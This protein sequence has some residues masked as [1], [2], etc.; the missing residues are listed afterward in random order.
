[1]FRPPF[2]I[3]NLTVENVEA[4][5]GYL[6]EDDNDVYFRLSSGSYNKVG[7]S[8]TTLGFAT[9]V[10]KKENVDNLKPFTK[11]MEDFLD[12]KVMVINNEANAWKNKKEKWIQEGSYL[13]HFLAEDENTAENEFNVFI[14]GKIAKVFSP[15]KGIEFTQPIDAYLFY[16]GFVVKTD[17]MP[18]LDS[19]VTIEKQSPPYAFGTAV[20]PLGDVFFGSPATVPTPAAKPAES[21]EMEKS[22]GPS[23]PEVKT[24]STNTD[25]FAAFLPVG[26]SGDGKG[27]KGAP[28]A[29]VA[30]E[31]VPQVFISLLPTKVPV[32]SFLQKSL[33]DDDWVK[34]REVPISAKDFAGNLVLHTLS[35]DTYPFG[36][37][38]RICFNCATELVLRY[39][40]KLKEYKEFYSPVTGVE[41][42]NGRFIYKE[43]ASK[44]A[45]DLKNPD[46]EVNTPGNDI[47][48][49]P[50]T[51]I[52]LYIRMSGDKPLELQIRINISKDAGTWIFGVLTR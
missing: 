52:G 29:E 8:G 50:P 22:S 42:W 15:T 16:Y 43:S 12:G 17:N 26:D 1:M 19:G 31:E 3:G 10:E 21:P 13:Y 32:S 7:E 51:A 45:V 5:R 25:D 20:I 23:S 37:K 44:N 41:R 30:T 47:W 39:A 18:N 48:E 34:V 33:V 46:L 24:S 14:K 2:I 27:T 6:F 9:D 11:D 35:P 4:M 28:A 36:K 40:P 49:T 38:V